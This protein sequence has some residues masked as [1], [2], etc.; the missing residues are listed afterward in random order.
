MTA[1]L[2]HDVGEQSFETE[3]L[4]APVPVLVEF[5]APWCGPCRA[6]SPILHKVAAETE[7][8]LKVVA[9]DADQHPSLAR[10]FGIRGLPTVIAF[11]GGKEVARHVGLTT[12]EKLLGMVE[13]RAP[14]AGSSEAASLAR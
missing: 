6:L 1:T 5:T 11:A 3:V 2:V 12:R 7:G 8:R 4:A 9:I 13:R 10:R 14:A